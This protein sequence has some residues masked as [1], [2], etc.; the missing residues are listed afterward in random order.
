MQQPA[1]LPYQQKLSAIGR[2]LDQQGYD[3]LLLCELADGFVVRAARGDHLPE[4]I[5]FPTSEL[6][7]LVRA[8]AEEGGNAK[9]RT[10]ASEGAYETIIRRVVGSYGEFLA[11]LGRQCDQLEA[12]TLLVM[13][14]SDSVLVAY[15]KPLTTFESWESCT[16]EYVYDEAGLRKLVL[17]SSFALKR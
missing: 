6:A 13:E 9:R 2:Y 7:M 1:H 15:Q 3:S 16:Y 11:A 8:S 10:P 4:A 5:P 17:G 14:M 12:S